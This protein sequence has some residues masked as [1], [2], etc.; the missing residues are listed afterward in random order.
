MCH[1]AYCWEGKYVCVLLCLCHRKLG[2]AE[3]WRCQV[4]QS[5]DGS[6]ELKK[7]ANPTLTTALLATYTIVITC[8]CHSGNKD[9][10]DLS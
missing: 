4:P 10:Y 6:R 1:P 9:I 5:G 3:K 8:I 2:E 7:A